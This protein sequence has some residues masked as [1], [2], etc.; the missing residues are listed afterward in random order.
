MKQRRPERAPISLACSWPEG[1]A[2]PRRTGNCPAV[3]LAKIGSPSQ[4]TQNLLGSCRFVNCPRRSQ[5]TAL[6]LKS[7][8][9]TSALDRCGSRARH[10]TAP[11]GV[12]AHR[13]QHVRPFLL[14][15][16]GLHQFAAQ[17]GRLDLGRLACAAASLPRPIVALA[18][19]CGS[20]VRSC[21]QI[22]C[23]RPR[24]PCGSRFAPSQ[25][26]EA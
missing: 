14:H 2:M 21:R 26:D 15:F 17:P 19:V 10:A 7:M 6:I 3:R 23:S 11:P 8:S 24:V 25:D 22:S 9:A 18:R 13:P 20:S 16:G 4:Q 5:S 12:H 1:P